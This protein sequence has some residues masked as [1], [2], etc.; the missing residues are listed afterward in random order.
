M[1]QHRN[2]NS[3]IERRLHCR[4]RKGDT[5]V[6]IYIVHFFRAIYGLHL[7]WIVKR[8][9]LMVWNKHLPA[10]HFDHYWFNVGF[11]LDT[12]SKKKDMKS[13][14]R[15]DHYLTSKRSM[16]YILLEL[17][18]HKRMQSGSQGVHQWNT[19]GLFYQDRLTLVLAW[20]TNYI[21]YEIKLYIHLHKS[22]VQR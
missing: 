4:P 6:W 16:H 13:V 18:G 15:S 21:K 10:G 1:H 5:F 14:A 17:R 12:P 2:V 20:T 9:S 11:S 7:A 3:W 8:F 19:L 22:L